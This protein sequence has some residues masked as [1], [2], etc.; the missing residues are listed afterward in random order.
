M[1]FDPFLR[2][3]KKWNVR[4]GGWEEYTHKGRYELSSLSL[5]NI[6]F[7]VHLLLIRCPLIPCAPERRSKRDVKNRKQHQSENGQEKIES[8]ENGNDFLMKMLKMRKMG[9]VW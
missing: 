7:Q 8:D 3:L 5:K 2:A 1:K 9:K 6:I 4:G